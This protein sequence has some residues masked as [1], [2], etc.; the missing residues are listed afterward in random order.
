MPREA[1]GRVA[2]A[3]AGAPHNGEGAAATGVTT[4]P[5]SRRCGG[6]SCRTTTGATISRV[7]RGLA[8]A[9]GSSVP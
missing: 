7:R 5:S 2:A 3:G 6:Q 4:A 8:V 1:R 9:A